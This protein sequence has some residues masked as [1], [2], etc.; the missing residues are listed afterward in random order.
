MRQKMSCS[1]R[2]RRLRSAAR[3][4]VDPCM[5][6]A[7]A[8]A[9]RCKRPARQRTSAF[10]AVCRCTHRLCQDV[11]SPADFM[12]F[13]SE[14]CING[15]NARRCNKAQA[16]F[17]SARREGKLPVRR[18]YPGLVRFDRGLGFSGSSVQLQ[19]PPLPQPQLPVEGDDRWTSR[20][21]A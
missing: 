4:I 1:I 18:D 3:R 13:C 19:Q 9:A 12:M 17:D 2:R 7:A 10:D 15:S 21:A 16:V 20:S 8:A 14:D 6:G 11:W 5:I